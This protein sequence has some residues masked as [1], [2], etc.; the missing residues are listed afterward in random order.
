MPL[1]DHW[2]FFVIFA[3][4]AVGLYGMVSSANKIKQLFSLS[5]FQGS[6]IL[7]FVSLGFAKGG[8]PPLLK[9]YTTEYIYHA[10]LPHVLMLTAIVVGIATM[11]VGLALV[12]ASSRASEKS[13]H[14]Q[15]PST[16]RLQGHS[17]SGDY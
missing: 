6:I 8:R 11:A 2:N 10:P 4:T 17:C 1:L 7:F 14:P 13:A 9:S 12:V 3:I 5:I 15:A 16:H